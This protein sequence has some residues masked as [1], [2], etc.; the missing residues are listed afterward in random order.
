MRAERASIWR[1]GGALSVPPAVYGADKFTREGMRRG[2]GGH[3]HHKGAGRGQERR[4]WAGRGLLQLLPLPKG[5][6][7]ALFRAAVYSKEDQAA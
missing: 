7:L 2:F 5:H 4:R 6:T 3:R 1:R